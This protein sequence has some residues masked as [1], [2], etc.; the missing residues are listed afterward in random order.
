MYI[1]IYIYI[2]IYLSIQDKFGIRVVARDWRQC[3]RQL[4]VSPDSRCVA[5]ASND[6]TRMTI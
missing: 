6:V 1:Y 3:W 4:C 5:N 2:S